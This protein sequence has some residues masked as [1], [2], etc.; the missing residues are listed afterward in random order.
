MYQSCCWSRAPLAVVVGVL[1]LPLGPC[2]HVVLPGEQ[3]VVVEGQVGQV[4]GWGKALVFL[5]K[6]SRQIQLRGRGGIKI[7]IKIKI[8][9][10]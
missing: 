8:V 7:K 5:F 6:V 4:H 2:P 3:V 9:K 1:L 10:F